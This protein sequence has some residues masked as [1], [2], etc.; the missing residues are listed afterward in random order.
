MVSI[1][2]QSNFT[3]IA[4]W[5][6]KFLHICRTSFPKNTSGGLL[7]EKVSTLSDT[8]IRTKFLVNKNQIKMRLVQFIKNSIQRV[9]VEIKQNGDIIDLSKINQSITKDMVTFLKSGEEGVN[10]AKK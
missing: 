2:L 10:L 6:C 7:L 1:K 4:L 3:D 8:K 9:G 5:S